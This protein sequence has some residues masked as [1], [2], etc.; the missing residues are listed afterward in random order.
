MSKGVAVMICLADAW[1]QKRLSLLREA[2][3]KMLSAGSVRPFSGPKACVKEAACAERPLSS[4]EGGYAEREPAQQQHKT[5]GR[6]G[7]G[8]EAAPH[9]GAHAEIAGEQNRAERHSA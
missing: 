6:S 5:A 3:R 8:K 2:M 9:I 1:S 4:D 7:A